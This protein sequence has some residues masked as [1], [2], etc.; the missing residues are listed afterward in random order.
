MHPDTLVI[1]M[2]SSVPNFTTLLGG[3]SH[4][5]PGSLLLVDTL[6]YATLCLPVIYSLLLCAAT[7]QALLENT[8]VTLMWLLQTS[9]S[10][11]PV[12]LSPCP[13]SNPTHKGNC[14]GTGFGH[15]IHP[16]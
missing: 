7:L 4:L 13:Y 5:L 16:Y 6:S 3:N 2:A 8:A 12:K 9:S 10:C 15:C 1:V 14:S 11:V